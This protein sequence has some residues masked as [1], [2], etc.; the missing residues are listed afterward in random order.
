MTRLKSRTSDEFINE[1]KSIH[2]N[3]YDYSKT[4]YFDTKS[5]VEITCHLHG[6]FLQSPNVH[7]YRSGCP[8]CNGSLKPVQGELI[9][10]SK[11]IHKDK[12]QIVGLN[13]KTNI[14][15]KCKV[16]GYVETEIHKFLNDNLGCNKYYFESA[17]D[18]LLN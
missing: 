4:I 15:F 12:Y 1:A 6:S 3:L 18:R 13:R 17:L 7:L 14:L 10:K 2:G 11:D 5:K 8:T 9:N 16:H